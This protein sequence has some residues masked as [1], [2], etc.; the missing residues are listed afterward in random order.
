MASQSKPFIS[1]EHEAISSTQATD[2]TG[3]VEVAV[4]FSMILIAVWTPQGHWN[5]FFCWAAG[6]LTVG[7]SLRGPYSAREVGL[8]QPL[9]GALSTIGI[10]MILVASITA[11]GYFCRSLGP[12]QPL[13]WE[14][15]WQYALWALL[16]QF[17]LQSFIFVRL[18]QSFGGR[19]AVLLASTLFA[20]AHVPSPL[21][22][23][24]SFFGALFFCHMFERYRNIYPLGLIHAALGLTIAA[25]MPDALMHHMRV[26]LGFLTYHP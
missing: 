10:G 11:L 13:P 22:T 17:I 3:L 26:G 16:Q 15:A 12:P 6:L 18:E 5:A 7:F 19:R 14:R 8:G 23:A 24:L 21:L 20:V 1:A 2:L 9:S 25:S 4:V